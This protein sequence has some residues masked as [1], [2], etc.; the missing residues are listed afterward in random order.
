[1]YMKRQK[2]KYEKTK[3]EV[4]DSLTDK[5]VEWTNVVSCMRIHDDDTSSARITQRLPTH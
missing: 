3:V 5:F 1:M 2:L 4:S